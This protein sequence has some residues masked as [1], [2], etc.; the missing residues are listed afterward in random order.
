[1][2]SICQTYMGWHRKLSLAI[3]VIVVAFGL[4]FWT[5]GVISSASVLLGMIVAYL[6]YLWE[7]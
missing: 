7:V 2:S 1:M 4:K 5:K 6:I 3:I